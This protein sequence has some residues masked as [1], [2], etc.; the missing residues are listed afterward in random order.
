[1]IKEFIFD[2]WD[3]KIS[4]KTKIY[5]YVTLDQFLSMVENKTNYFKRLSAWDDTWEA[6]SRNIPTEHEDGRLEYASY[7]ISQDFF[8]QCWTLKEESDAMWRIYSLDNKGLRISTSIEKLKMIEGINRL[9]CGKVYYYDK[10][11]EGL[12]FTKTKG[13]EAFFREGIIKRHA[14]NHEEEIRFLTINQE[15]F[16]QNRV[17]NVNCLEFSFD[18]ISIID[19]ITI[20]PR[21]KEYYVETIKNYC[22]RAGFSIIPVKSKL[23]DDDIYEKERIVQ[24]WVSVTK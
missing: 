19:E 16:V 5:R 2:N 3:N 24:K 17:E 1:M 11:I 23:Y 20:D 15:P 8:G 21:A 4:E 12:E 6:P 9:Y 22:K 13:K 14:F 10:L 7:S 18:P